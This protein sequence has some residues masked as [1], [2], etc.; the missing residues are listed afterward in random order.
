MSRDD[1]LVMLPEWFRKVKEYPE[2][3]AAW[4]YALSVMGDNI[5]QVWA[6]QYIQTCDEDTLELYEKLLGITPDG[7]ATIEYRRAVVLNKYS[8]IVP[9]TESFLIDRLN[10][11]FGQDGY[12]LTI[13]SEHCTADI[14]LLA[15]I[16]RAK[17]IFLNFWYGIAPAHI[18]VTA[19]EEGHSEIDGR[20][21]FGGV[22]M[23]Q[24]EHV[25]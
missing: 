24:V 5:T 21:F 25:F 20:Q 19:H 18:K 10:D 17:D 13:D 11:M 7:L 8:M 16:A 1:L 12:V 6:N 14:T 3:M 22:V 2:I 23:S 4:A 15:E 9:F